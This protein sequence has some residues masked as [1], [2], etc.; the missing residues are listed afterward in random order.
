MTRHAVHLGADPLVA[1]RLARLGIEL[2][3]EWRDGA[4]AI[5]PVVVV[6]DLGP[7]EALAAIGQVH[8]AWPRALVAGYLALPDSERWV[9]AQRAGADLVANRGALGS[10]LRT[11]LQAGDGRRLFPLMDRVDIAGRL[12]L[13]ARI[14]T[15]PVGPVAVYQVDGEVHV[16][17]DR[18][19]HAG[20]ALS[21]GELDHR[22]VTCPRHGSQF[23]VCTGERVR[24]PADS[25]LRRF[26]VVNEG[27]QL[28]IDIGTGAEAAPLN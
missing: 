15:D 26:R 3:L 2:D 1:G 13:V 22:I 9:A 27:G 25:E 16:L 6:I 5:D 24:G 19:P 21:E 20:A 11:L 7:A 4:T 8:E 14:D 23:D 17:A 12:G 10:R 18:C 28:C